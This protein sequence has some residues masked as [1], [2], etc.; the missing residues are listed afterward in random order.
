[1][2]STLSHGVP[3]LGVARSH[4][5]QM[6]FEYYGFLE[7]L[8]NLHMPIDELHKK[9]NLLFNI[10][11]KEKIVSVIKKNNEKQKYQAKKCGMKS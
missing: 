10:T 11:S 1:L 7:G 9:M 6:L 4:D 2:V 3:T 8:L 5:Y